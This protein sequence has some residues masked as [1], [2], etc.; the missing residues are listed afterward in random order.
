M[1]L[2]GERCLLICSR[3]KNNVLKWKAKS[4]IKRYTLATSIVHD[5]EISGNLEPYLQRSLG[6]G[7]KF[8]ETYA[9][10]RK[11]CT[12][13]MQREK[14]VDNPFLQTIFG[15]LQKFRS[16]NL[17]KLIKFLA[18]KRWNLENGLWKELENKGI[19]QNQGSQLILIKP[20]MR[21]ALINN[22]RTLFTT[23]LETMDA[24]TR[25]LLGLLRYSIQWKNAFNGS[26][27]DKKWVKAITRDDVIS[28]IFN[29]LKKRHE[30]GGT[31]I[32]A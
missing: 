9:D 22:V 29:D 13:T 30:R 3:Y 20:E 31:V 18:N 26:E 23:K 10:L 27:W 11:L 24:P 15:R 32:W 2:I 6:F 25:A 14:P 28:H 7:S 21:E 1:L 12:F 19:I 16:N 5:L 17:S 4:W 8:L